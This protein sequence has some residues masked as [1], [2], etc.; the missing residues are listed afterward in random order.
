VPQLSGAI[1]RLATIEGQPPSLLDPPT[2]C[3]FAPRC[4]YADQ[5]CRAVYPPQF[6]VG[7]GHTADCWRLAPA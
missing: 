6:T 4:A 1:G 3:R 7:A 5:R 2:G